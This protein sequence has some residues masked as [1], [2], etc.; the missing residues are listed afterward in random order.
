MTDK[1]LGEEI[2]KKSL[3]TLSKGMMKQYQKHPETTIPQIRDPLTKQII[4]KLEE[5]QKAFVI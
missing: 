4:T 5:I 3:A 1:I 2:Q